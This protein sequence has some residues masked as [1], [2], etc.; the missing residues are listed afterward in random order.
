MKFIVLAEGPAD[1]VVDDVDGSADPIM[2]ATNGV[3]NGNDEV[4]PTGATLVP[5]PEL[6]L[7]PVS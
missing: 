6:A 5:V 4:C 7:L 3:M 1:P 2:L